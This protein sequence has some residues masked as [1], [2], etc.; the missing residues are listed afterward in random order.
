MPLDYNALAK[1]YKPKVIKTLII[2]EAPPSCGTKYFYKAFQMSKAKLENDYSLPA[3]IF[4]HYFGKKPTDIDEYEKMLR[5]LQSNNIFLIDIHDEPIQV[6]TRKNGTNRA[7]MQKV[8]DSICLLKNKIQFVCGG[9]PE[10]IIYLMPRGGYKRL[11]KA[12]C[13]NSSYY[14]WKEFRIIPAKHLLTLS[15]K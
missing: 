8:K 5:V 15:L 6:A 14:G 7:N 2:G 10:E 4:G 9:L 12:L 1:S 3:T 11:L 13:L